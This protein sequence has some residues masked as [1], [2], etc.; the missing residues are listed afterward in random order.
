MQ[1]QLQSQ[2]RR[3]AVSETWLNTISNMLVLTAL[4]PAEP[5]A[6][7]DLHLH[8][9]QLQGTLAKAEPKDRLASVLLCMT[10]AQPQPGFS[11]PAS[12]IEQTVVS[13][14]HQS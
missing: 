13:A 10:P 9:D 3:M 6:L 5:R 2:K 14:F 11:G 7:L 8:A 4:C 12:Q 1:S